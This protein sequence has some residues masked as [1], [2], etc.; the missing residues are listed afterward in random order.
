MD[1]ITGQHRRSDKDVHEYEDGAAEDPYYGLWR[2][3]SNDDYE[4]GDV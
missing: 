2:S 1:C 4:S 3:I